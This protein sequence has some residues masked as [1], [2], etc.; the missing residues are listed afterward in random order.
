MGVAGAEASVAVAGEA[1]VPRF[2]KAR[3]EATLPGYKPWKKTVYVPASSMTVNAALTPAQML[4]NL[5]N[6]LYDPRPP[7]FMTNRVAGPA[8][9]NEFRYYRD[10]NRNGPRAFFITS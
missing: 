8:G 6:L 5:E 4:Q 9:S 7:V 2:E 1:S 10:E 3:V